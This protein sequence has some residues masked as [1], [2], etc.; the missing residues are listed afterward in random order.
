MSRAVLLLVL[1]IGAIVALLMNNHEGRLWL[2]DRVHDVQ[3]FVQE[4]RTLRPR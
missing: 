1:V 3:W 4:V 2:E